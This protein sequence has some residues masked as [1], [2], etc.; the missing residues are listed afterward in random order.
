MKKA[1][2]LIAAILA[3]SVLLNGTAVMAKQSKKT[4][5]KSKTVKLLVGKKKK[6]TLKNRKKKAS[7]IFKSSVPKVAKVSKKG[8]ITAVKTGKAKITVR[9]KQGKKTKKIGTVK[10]IVTSTDQNTPSVPSSPSPTAAATGTPAGGA[11]PG[12]TNTPAATAT[13]DPTTEPTLKPTAK[14]T[15]TPAQPSDPRMKATPG[16]LATK[17]NGVPYGEVKEIQ[18]YST[19][20]EKNRNAVVILPDGYSEQKK[21]PVLYLFHGGMGDE[22]DWLS[23]NVQTMIGNM[24]ASKEAVEM[25]IVLPNCRCRADDS[26]ANADGFALGHVQSFDNFIND[27]RDN[28]MPYISQNYSVAEGRENTAIAGLSMGGR[29]SLHIGISLAD[30]VGYT[31]AFSP[32]YGIFAYTNNGLTEEGLFTEETFTLPNEYKDNTFIMINNGYQDT[33]V[34]KEPERYHNALAAN[35]VEHIYYMINGGHDWQVWRNGFYNFARYLFH[36]PEAEPTPT[37]IGPKEFEVPG[38][39][40]KADENVTY[41]TKKTDTYY[42]TTT[43]KERKVNIIL[44]PDYTEE[45]KYPVLYLL[46]GIG[47]DENEW[48][49]GTPQY[50]IGNLVKRG[51]A[52]EMILVLPNCRARENDKATT[53]FTLEHYAAFDNFINDL[54]DNL[55]PYMKQNYSIAEGRENTAIAGLSMGGRES[56]NIG[57]NMPE[58]FGYIAAFSP[59]YGVFAYE[60]NGVAEKGLFTEETFRLPDEYKDNTLLLINNGSNEGGENALGGTCHKVL[61]NNGIPHL[62]YVTAGGHEMKVWKHGLY[63]FATRIFQS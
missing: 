60:A 63:N 15:P 61:T 8:V 51:L 26:A 27:F 38:D 52:K 32:A 3:F 31:G 25:I 30:K 55:M 12:P 37:P 45:K 48:M 29:V 5:I 43:K 42:S 9:E 6:I 58:T 44:P 4:S 62:F 36:D 47:G 35:G 2:K 7:Y 17:Q 18:Y 14:P 1:M 28:L 23:G 13:A 54:R 11:V 33:M 24:Y 53:E 10:V 20:T 56:L 59:G 49:S 34:S 46:H 21:Y 41:G 16:N 19:T 39:Y 50:I 40:D 57:L 22:K